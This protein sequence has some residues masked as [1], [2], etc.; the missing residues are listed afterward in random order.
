MTNFETTY[1]V[2][3]K[4]YAAIFH[5]G[6][7]LLDMAER[8]EF[9]RLLNLQAATVFFAF[10]FEAYLNHV[11]AEELP[12]WEKKERI[13]YEKKLTVLS[14]HLGFTKDVSKPPFKTILQL[15]EL[16]NALAHGRTQKLPPIKITSESPPP[17][18]SVCYLLPMEQLTPEIVRHYYDD[19]QAATELINS[20]R[21]A[22]DKLLW[23][24]GSRF[25]TI[26]AGK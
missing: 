19:V 5:T 3:S 7:H 21:R 22:P 11:G 16:R 24:Q 8:H 23:N 6:W 10:A 2:E 13:P 17:H 12:F 1:N 20:A 4:T 9:G 15:F 14:K 25:R 18:D 26:S